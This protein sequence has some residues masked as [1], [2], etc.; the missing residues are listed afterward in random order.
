[1]VMKTH[2]VK[3]FWATVWMGLWSILI[4]SFTLQQG[5]SSGALS[6]SIARSLYDWVVFLDRLK[7]LI[8]FELFHFLLRKGAHFF[9]YFI[10]GLLS[11]NAL[12]YYSVI[13]FRPLIYLSTYGFFFAFV[14]E[15][16]Q[17]FVPGRAFSWGDIVID[18]LGFVSGMM[19]LLMT[20]RFLTNQES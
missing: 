16:I 18:T 9:V 4:V 20:H 5:E 3:R 12:K 6:G 15:T 7:E 1:M 11:L 14:D 2:D 13:T 8:P 10:Y 17:R 19:V